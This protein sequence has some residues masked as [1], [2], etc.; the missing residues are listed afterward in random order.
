MSASDTESVN[1]DQVHPPTRL[2]VYKSSPVKLSHV[3]D[4]VHIK[5]STGKKKLRRYQDSKWKFF[6]FK[7]LFAITL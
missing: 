4:L 1:E 2:R 5:K 6:T 7:A 3:E